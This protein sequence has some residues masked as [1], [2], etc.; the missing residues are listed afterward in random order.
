M[1]FEPYTQ[2]ELAACLRLFDLNCPRFFQEKSDQAIRISYSSRQV[3]DP[4][5]LSYSLG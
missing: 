1:E 3:Q 2:H 5:T 4:R